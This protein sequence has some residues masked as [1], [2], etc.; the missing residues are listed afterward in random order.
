MK[1]IHGHDQWSMMNPP[2]SGPNNA[3]PTNASVK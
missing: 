2:I 1:K 3:A